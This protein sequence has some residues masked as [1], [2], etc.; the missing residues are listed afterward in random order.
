MY[1]ILYVF[2]CVRQNAKKGSLSSYLFVCLS[3]SLLVHPSVHMEQLGSQWK[4]FHEIWYLKIFRK[5]VEKNLSFIKIRR[6]KL[7]IFMQTYIKF[8]TISGWMFLGLRNISDKNC[9]EN[10]NVFFV[11]Q[12][13]FRKSCPL[14]ESVDKHGGTRLSGECH[15]MRR[16]RDAIF[17][18]HNKGKNTDTYN[19]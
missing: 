18:P 19:T 7:V 14:W 9:R 17:M 12:I 3:V 1:L 10:Q 6:K 16:W 13:R 2:I 15:K 5:T 11:Q 4:N 8:M